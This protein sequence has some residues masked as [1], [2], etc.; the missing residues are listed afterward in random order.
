MGE[1]RGVF[2]GTCWAI[3]DGGRVVASHDADL[4]VPWWSFTK[5]V[6]AAAALTLVRDGAL[7]LDAALPGRPYT[8][9]QLLQHRSGLTNY[10]ELAAYHAAV[11]RGDEPWSFEE[12]C[13]RLDADRLLY[14]PGHGWHYSNIGY[15]FVAR[16][17]EEQLQLPLDSALRQRVLRPLGIEGAR[18]AA[19]PEDLNGV[20][21]GV[22]GYHPGWVYHG[23]LVGTVAEAALLLHRLF[24]GPLL[25]DA[26]RDEMATPFC[27]P[28]PIPGRP[29]IQPGYG[30][31][32]MCGE[33]TAGSVAGHTG[34]GPGSTIAV[35][36]ALSASGRTAA[37]FRT[38]ENQGIT[39]GQALGLLHG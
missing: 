39:E 33:T 35:Y 8:L 9:R 19:T 30:L 10:G 20:T 38:A 29:W 34:G 13:G 12:L 4:L 27:L 26:L 36:R 14:E 25:P 2:P 5:T 28:G 16:L 11:A 23:L 7:T 3:V 17:I 6:L 31:G 22:A 21:M 18:V 32:I 37:A 1:G 24:E 15:A